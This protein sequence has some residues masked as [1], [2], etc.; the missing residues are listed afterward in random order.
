MRVDQG[1]EIS[2]AGHQR[3][4][5]HIEKKSRNLHRDHLSLAANEAAYRQGAGE[6]CPE[7]RF[8][9]SYSRGDTDVLSG[10]S[11]ERI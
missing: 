9:R 5:R 4:R 2:R 11:G 6:L 3:E 1:T 7:Q 8:Q 10:R